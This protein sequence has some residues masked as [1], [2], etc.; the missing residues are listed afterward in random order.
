MRKKAM[1]WR[2]WSAWLDSFAALEILLS[3]SGV[4]LYNVHAL[5]KALRTPPLQ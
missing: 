5:G 3:G 4:R 2:N 1:A